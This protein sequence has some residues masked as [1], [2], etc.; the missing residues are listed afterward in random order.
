ML[1]LLTVAAMPL[2]GHVT[3]SVETSE[4]VLSTTEAQAEETVEVTI[5]TQLDSGGERLT[6][7]DNFTPGFGDSANVEIRS[8]EV[9]GQATLPVAAVTGADF[10]E[11]ALEE[12]FQANDTITIVYGVTVP[13]DTEDG[14][15][16]SF[17]GESAL[18]D[19]DPVSHSG[20]DELTVGQPDLSVTGYSATPTEVAPEE[21]VAVEA[22]VSND[23]AVGG[24]IVVEFLV[25]GTVVETRNVSLEGGES[26]T[27]QFNTSFEE[28]GNHTV[29]VNDLQT[30]EIIVSEP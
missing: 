7:E 30:T 4:R 1:V 26:T 3:A 15:I 17:S 22:N 5:E 10:I 21:A 29:T 18:D 23:G 14:Q 19:T 27:V 28:V 16:F 11:V 6:I 2:I 12:D 20:D 24:E 13:E 25:D 8:V 9:N